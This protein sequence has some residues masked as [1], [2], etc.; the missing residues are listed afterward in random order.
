MNWMSRLNQGQTSID[1]LVWWK[2]GLAISVVLVIVSIVSLST[3]GLNLGIDFEGGV[4]WEVQ[5]PGVSVEKARSELATVGEAQ[6]K[7]QIVGSD[8]LRVQGPE[9]T[10]EHTAEVRQ[11]L[12]EIAGA[13]TSDVSVSTVG[14]SW[15]ADVTASA[16]RALVFFAIAILIYLSIR[17]EWRMAVAAVFAVVHDVLISVGVYSVFQFEVSVEWLP[18]SV[19]PARQK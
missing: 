6:A 19:H 2:R 1:F 15:G 8:I 11:K 3:R 18:F 4:S 10:P 12:A 13:E 5:A 7:I 9:S 16:L 17:L 14:A